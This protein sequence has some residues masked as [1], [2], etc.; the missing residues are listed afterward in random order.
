MTKQYAERDAMA[1]DEAGG[2]YMRH[3]MAMTGEKLHGKG[4]IA[5][6]LGWRDMQITAL[7]QKLDAANDEAAHERNR[8]CKFEA[9]CKLLQ[10]KLEETEALMYAM[11]HDMRE[12][13]EKMEAMLAENVVLKKFCKNA[14]FDADYEAELGME[15]GGF[16]DALNDTKTPATDAILNEVRAEALIKFAEEADRKAEAFDTSARES[17]DFTED[18]R[19]RYVAAMF[20]GFAKQLRTGSNE[21]GV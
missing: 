6:E 10:Q 7:Q 2:Y 1:L 8:R 13:R 19:F 17:A 9:D 18:Q 5:A 14:A 20:R 12:S 4:D 15:C 3:V 16:T 11:R 21:G